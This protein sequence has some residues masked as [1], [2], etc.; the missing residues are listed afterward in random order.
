MHSDD[1]LYK[2][3]LENCISV[4]VLR[5]PAVVLPEVVD[6]LVKNNRALEGL[7]LAYPQRQELYERTQAFWSNLM[8][9]A[10]LDPYCAADYAKELRPGAC[11]QRSEDSRLGAAR[12]VPPLSNTGINKGEA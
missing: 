10:S 3:W 5:V 9:L 1:P 11:P 12:S 8:E 7:T 4:P 2:A 6:F